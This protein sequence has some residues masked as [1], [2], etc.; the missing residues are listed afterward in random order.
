MSIVN[1]INFKHWT[2]EQAGE[3][4]QVT[5]EKYKKIKSFQDV[6]Y[7]LSYYVV[8]GGE[9]TKN[10]K[11]NDIIDVSDIVAS[12][13]DNILSR[14]GANFETKIPNTTYYLDFDKSG[15]WYWGAAH[16][17]GVAGEDYLTIAD[18]LTDAS[19]LVNLIVDK[20]G[21]VGGM[22]LKDEF[23]LEG[24]AKKDTVNAQLAV[25]AKKDELSVN[26]K[27]YGA[28]GDGVTDDTV[29]IK[30]CLA[31]LS[32]KSEHLYKTVFFP[33]GQY[34]ISATIKM[35][36]HTSFV[37]N[38]DAAL[39]TK[40]NIDML[41]MSQFCCIDGLNLINKLEGY[42]KSFVTISSETLDYADPG[43]Y[44]GS[45][46]IKVLNVRAR[47]TWG[48]T[49]TFL[50]MWAGKNYNG[51]TYTN[52]G[53]SDVTF[54]NVTVDI[55]FEYFA[56]MYSVGT[57]YSDGWITTV[58]FKDVFVYHSTYG[59]VEYPD[60]S[61]VGSTA[62]RGGQ[63]IFL[64]NYFQQ[65]QAVNSKYAYVM[66]DGAK[67]I[68]NTVFWD[69]PDRTNPVGLSPV[70]VGNQNTKP[71]IS[72]DSIGSISLYTD[73]IY[74]Y[75][76]IHNY[77]GSIAE[78]SIDIMKCFLTLD[79]RTRTN[80]FKNTQSSRQ[81]LHYSLAPNPVLGPN[82]FSTWAT[83]GVIDYSTYLNYG[84]VHFSIFLGGNRF[85]RG[86][87]E[88][89]VT[90]E[91]LRDGSGNVS[92]FK[93]LTNP[94]LPLDIVGDFYLEKIADRKY[95]LYAYFV[96]HGLPSYGYSKI[97][98]NEGVATVH[99]EMLRTAEIPDSTTLS[100]YMKATKQPVGSFYPPQFSDTTAMGLSEG[101]LRYN[102]TSKKLEFWNNTK[103]ETVTST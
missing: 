34:L 99:W 71:L 23:G 52:V 72:T 35:P 94:I 78:E 5:Y 55:T 82:N 66:N 48:N 32:N 37:A 73:S 50:H 15:D 9:V 98:G 102:P 18:V 69:Y 8:S 2:S 56:R 103:W 54:D 90:L 27:D 89:N 24:Y 88:V 61:E 75:M 29:A 68:Y 45:M 96:N 12:L 10:I 95:K 92:S 76:R 91:I 3:Q 57:S 84:Y 49:G 65:A 19:G 11:R 77:L 85:N 26:V 47:S 4:A 93:V 58:V 33:P 86:I 59:I 44:Y 31:D 97:T 30:N 40:T 64:D 67:H 7:L 28:K 17:P 70:L 20:R 101:A 36:I 53:I 80:M 81:L 60:I 100:T 38:K 16:A 6:G 14:D 25:T 83:T 22:R 51:G 87:G 1:N 13:D 41:W 79:V 62:Y 63:D 43:T 39:V 74:K 21:H 42:S 46:G